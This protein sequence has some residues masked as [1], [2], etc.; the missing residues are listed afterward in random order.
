M[1]KIG[2]ECSADTAGGMHHTVCTQ[3]KISHLHEHS[4]CFVVT[5]TGLADVITHHSCSRVFW[6]HGVSIVIVAMRDTVNKL[7]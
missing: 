2:T 7:S 6:F 5:A 4:G 3:N 1:L